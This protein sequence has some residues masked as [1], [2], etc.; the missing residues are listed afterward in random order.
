MHQNNENIKII[1]LDNGDDIVCALPKEQYE[2]KH[3]LLKIEKPLQVKYVPQLTPEGFKDY[4]ALIKWAPYT[5]D[6]IVTIPKS[7]ILTVTT[8]TE[9][10]KHSYTEIVREY[11]LVDKVPS[12]KEVEPKRLSNDE[13]K[14]INDIFDE[15]DDDPNGPTFH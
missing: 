7:K 12:R 13:N 15:F 14:K 11:S 2:D 8:A 3:L 6:T 5:S 4:V 1:K 9:Q 10:M